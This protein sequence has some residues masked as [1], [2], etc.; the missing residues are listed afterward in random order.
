MPVYEYRALN[1]AG[2]TVSG[3][4]DADGESAAREKL[5][6]QKLFPETIREAYDHGEKKTGRK[7][8]EPFLFSGIR[9]GE[10]ATA[11]RQLSTLVGSGFPLVSAIYALI[12]QAGSPALKKVLSR[13]KDA[14]EEGNS[15][16]DALAGFPDVFS[17]IYINMVRAG[18]ASGTLEIVLERLAELHEKQQAQRNR[19]TAILAYPMVMTVL[20]SAVL[21]FLLVKIVPQLITV[22]SDMNQ[23]LPTPTRVVILV[24]GFLQSYW[25]LLLAAVVLIFLALGRIRKTEKGVYLID[26][27]ILRIPGLKGL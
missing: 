18:E 22:F 2:K 20:G 17:P 23:A 3:I 5:R 7:W 15:F 25:W 26:R 10:L 19:I 6:G 11:T 12:P 4:I 13:L 21:V 9:K 27:T 1:A 14:I 16:A 24:S 8:F